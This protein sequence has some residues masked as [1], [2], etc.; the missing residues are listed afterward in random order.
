MYILLTKC[1]VYGLSRKNFVR[2]QALLYNT[3]TKTT[4]VMTTYGDV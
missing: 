1:F 4:Y 2:M 3:Y